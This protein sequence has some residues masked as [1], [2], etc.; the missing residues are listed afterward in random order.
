MTRA[1]AEPPSPIL[2]APAHRS[3]WR[4]QRVLVV[5]AGLSGAVVA[6]ELADAGH[7]VTVIEAR[8]HLAGNCHTERDAATGVMEHRYGPHIFHTDDAEVWRYVNRF[9]QFQPYEHRVR[10]VAQGQVYTMPVSLMTLCQIRG[11]QMSPEAARA[12]LAAHCVGGHRAPRTFEEAALSRVGPRL[13]ELLFKGYTEKAWGRSAR[14]VPVSVFERIPIRF[15]YDDTYFDHTF[16]GLPKAGY[17]AMVERM[18]AHPGIE[19][20]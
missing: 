3:G 14:E 16:S 17:T 10:T 5:G 1:H 18:L 11:A 6:R 7:R 20:V 13:Y 2:F 8:D 12:W 4:A 9:A 19:V 15:D